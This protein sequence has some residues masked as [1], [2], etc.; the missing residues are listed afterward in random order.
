MKIK[1]LTQQALT[2]VLALAS[3]LPLTSLAQMC[4]SNA[5]MTTP[6]SRFIDNGDGVLIDTKTHLMWQKCVD[7]KTGSSCETGTTQTYS[8]QTAFQRVES[9]N[10]TTG[11]AGFVDWRLPNAKELLSIMERSCMAPAINLQL[12]PNVTA[13]VADVWSSTPYFAPGNFNDRALVAG[14]SGLGG[15]SENMKTYSRAIR[16]VRTVPESAN[17][18]AN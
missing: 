16:L 9:L 17:L 11:F 12:F 5:L 10:N 4:N 7:G 18:T 15:I 1:L 13:D 8:W 3:L 6:A 2:L 14:F